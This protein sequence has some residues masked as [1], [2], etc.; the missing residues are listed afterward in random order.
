MSA[1]LKALAVA[2]TAALAIPLLPA[3]AGASATDSGPAVATVRGTLTR[4]VAEPSAR[5]P[6]AKPVEFASLTV[7]GTT[8]AV[9]P[10]LAAGITGG[11]KVTARIRSTSASALTASPAA[12]ARAV[13]AGTATVTT[14]KAESASPSMAGEHKVLVVPVYWTSTLP[15]GQPTTAK[16]KGDLAETDAYYDTVTAGKLRVPASG[17]T[18]LPWQKLNLGAAAQGDCYTDLTPA[19]ENAVRA[20]KIADGYSVASY[21]EDRFHHIVAY[22]PKTATCDYDGFA[23][24]GPGFSGNAFMWLNGTMK[25]SVAAHELGHNLGLDHSGEYRCYADAAETVKTTMTGSCTHTTYQEDWGEI[26]GNGGLRGVTGFMSAAHLDQLGVLPTGGTRTLGATS[27]VTLAPLESGAGLRGITI[28]VGTRTYY[29]EYRVA[30]GIDTWIGDQTWVYDDDGEPMYQTAEP[31][32]GLVVRMTDSAAPWYQANEQDYLDFHPEY[33]SGPPWIRRPG[34]QAGESWTAPDK[35]IGFAVAPGAGASGAT[36]T[37][38]RRADTTP[39]TAFTLT[40]PEKQAVYDQWSSITAAW[41]ETTDADSGLASV[42]IQLDGHTIRSYGPEGAE[43]GE[44]D[45][46]DDVPDGKHTLQVTATD[47]AGNKRVAGPVTFTR[48]TTGPSI[49]K[50]PTAV[51][52][53]GT[54]STTSVPVTLSWATTDALSPI[55]FQH[56]DNAASA[57]WFSEPSASTRSLKTVAYAGKKNAWKL[58]VTDSLGNESKATGPS[59][60]ATLDLQNSH[61]TGY[62]GTWATVKSTSCLGGSEQTTTKAKSKLTYTVTARSV[63]WI[64]TKTSKRGKAQVYVDGHLLTTVDLYAKSTT[65]KQQVWAYSWPTSGKHTITVVNQATSGRPTIGIDAIARLS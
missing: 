40:S 44:A 59:T 6:D 47:L 43:L 46:S 33:Q 61:T 13:N 3:P 1:R 20:L 41:G 11:T 65:T 36:V 60:S 25:M 39:P 30:T 22:F 58:D 62:S 15:D 38:T 10:D 12:L 27:T 23:N 14:L 56:L 28:P 64:A 55:D 8:V 37:I 53:T 32:G 42:D 17:V 49:T 29:V 19:I 4:T 21:P 63:A 24:L 51:L 5:H 18:V 50:R 48:D 26:M 34:L 2:A 7:D 35:S 16:L 54:A 9:R 31:D 57:S 52:R 45:L